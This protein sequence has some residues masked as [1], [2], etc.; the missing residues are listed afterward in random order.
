M[1]KRFG[2]YKERD[3]YVTRWSY[4]QVIFQSMAMIV[5]KFR[6]IHMHEIMELL[7]F[8]MFCFNQ[9]LYFYTS[10]SKVSLFL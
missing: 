4:S 1:S 3:A 2:F 10:L 8:I 9:L 5:T 7:K 6:C